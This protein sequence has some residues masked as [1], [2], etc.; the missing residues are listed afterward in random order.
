MEIRSIECLLAVAE[1][2]SL[3]S[4]AQVLG[5]TQPALT[6]IVRRIEDEAGA[7][8]F[9]RT[10]RGVRPTV[11][12]EAMLRHARNLRVS[13]RASQR[14][15]AALKAG[16]AGEVRVGAGPSWERVI[17][18]EAVAAFRTRRPGVRVR[19]AGGTDDS[20]K[21]RLREGTL[22]FVLAATPDAPGL[23][24]DLAWVP[25][26]MDEYCVIAAQAHPLAA[27]A[28][29]ALAD[30]LA[31]P[32]TLPG[33]RSLMVQ[34]LHAAFHAQGLTP[35][36]TAVETDIVA[37]RHQLLTSGPYLS[38]TAAELTTELAARAVVRLDVPGAVSR[39]VAGVIT[40]RRM[41]QSPA[42][43]ELIAVIAAM[44]GRAAPAAQAG[45]SGTV[46]PAGISEGRRPGGGG[47][48]GAAPAAGLSPHAA[49]A[50]ARS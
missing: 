31:Y 36:D 30:L 33:P 1:H 2:G 38:C 18:P 21:L 34:R 25:L 29:I 15:I 10:G 13:L 11:C 48:R 16:L 14:E 39:R 22:D 45:L 23:D 26:T 12:G 40:R 20:L 27:R 47:F 4:A 35:P 8:L 24:P 41:E 5:I 28:A 37:L 7:R 32:W 3:R 6:K 44:A 46:P 9:D 19:I 49:G 42:A 43:A 17:L 50:E